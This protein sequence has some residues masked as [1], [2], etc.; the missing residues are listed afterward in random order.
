M[1]LLI[2]QV[3]ELTVTENK[4]VIINLELEIYELGN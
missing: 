1:V 2:I 4:K 3:L